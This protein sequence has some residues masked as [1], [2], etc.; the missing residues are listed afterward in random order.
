MYKISGLGVEQ[1]HTNLSHSHSIKAISQRLAAPQKHSYL[2]DAVLGGIDGCVTTFAIVASAVGAGF[3]NG[4]ALILGLANLAAD[5]FSMAVS[6]YQATKSRADLI[7]MVRKQEESHIDLVPEG[8]TEEIRQIFAKKGFSGDILE[9]IVGV[10]T[11]NRTLWVD[12]MLK[13][14]YGLQ[15]DIPNSVMSAISTFL[16]F[17]FVG[18]LPLIPFIANY[19]NP[20]VIFPISCGIAAMAFFGIGVVKGVILKQSILRAGI[21]TLLVGGAA[22]LLAYMVGDFSSEWIGGGWF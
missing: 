20:D 6:N 14:E 22:A 11:S 1:Q 5:G 15:T 8:E 4:V 12:T 21:N 17:L 16:A 9:K 3:P 19:N 7:Q 10:I 2:A 13:D 18:L